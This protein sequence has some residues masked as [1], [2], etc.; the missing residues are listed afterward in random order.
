MKKINWHRLFHPSKTTAAIIVLALIA[1][2]L[3]CYGGS[4]GG[5]QLLFA[6]TPVSEK[7]LR[8]HV[9]ANSDSFFDQQ[10]K[11]QMRDYIIT[12][13]EPQL[14]SAQSKDEAM[15]IIEASLPELNASCNQFLAGRA[16]YQATVALE[17]TDFPRIDYDGLV[18]AEGEYD[19]LRIVLG[20]GEGHNWWCVLFPPLCFVDLAGEYP[21]DATAAV[22]A[23]YAGD[24]DNSGI[25][26]KWK[27]ADLFR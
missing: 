2:A 16:N 5:G 19:A 23:S 21:D 13:I 6:N 20:S 9:L 25:E 1:V 22:W 18:L 3:H 11:L 17:R 7:P 26:V 14:Q 15:A 4:G 12:V 27:L 8:L 10:L 24:E